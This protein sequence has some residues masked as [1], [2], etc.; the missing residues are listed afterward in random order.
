MFDTRNPSP[1]T[2][3]AREV[4]RWQHIAVLH[5]ALKNGFQAGMYWKRG[6]IRL[7]KSWTLLRLRGSG[8]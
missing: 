1:T 6:G 2:G 4:E 8:G 7:F 3:L 5:G